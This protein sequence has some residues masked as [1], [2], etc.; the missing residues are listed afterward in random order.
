MFLYIYFSVLIYFFQLSRIVYWKITYFR[1][2]KIN[3]TQQKQNRTIIINVVWAVA[4]IGQ[5]SFILVLPVI[6]RHRL[7]KFLYCMLDYCLF[8]HLIV[9]NKQTLTRLWGSF[10]TGCPQVQLP[11]K[12]GIYMQINAQNLTQ[13][14]LK[15][16]KYF[17]TSFC[18][19]I[20]TNI[21]E[22]HCYTMKV[23]IKIL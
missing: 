11:E 19:N 8:A 21:D 9:L 16:C 18:I 7:L 12:K 2:R 23:D 10:Q 15:S 17:G 14:V 4:Y 1:V 20:I 13:Y 22:V 6:C 3:K 5:C